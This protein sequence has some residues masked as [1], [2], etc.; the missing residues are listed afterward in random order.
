MPGPDSSSDTMTVPG[1]DSADD[2]PIMPNPDGDSD[3]QV[4]PELPLQPKN[5]GPA[6]PCTSPNEVC[7]PLGQVCMTTCTTSADCPPW[8]DTC[9]D[10]RDPRGGGRTARVCGCTGA[11]VCNNYANGFTCNPFDNLCE[12]SCQTQQ[13]CSGFMPPRKCDTFSGWC[14]STLPACANNAD[15]PSASQP[16]CDPTASRCVGCI[17]PSDCAGRSDGLTQCSPGGACSGP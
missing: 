9:T 8:L 6:N 11:Q 1:P 10:V 3:A 7:H 16:R 5:C 4:T 14:Q 2:A 12:R 13:D 15:C 17:Q